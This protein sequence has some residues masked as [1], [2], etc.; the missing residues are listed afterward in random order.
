[1][2]EAEQAIAAA[3]AAR[4]AADIERRIAAAAAEADAAER[5]TSTKPT[6]DASKGRSSSPSRWKCVPYIFRR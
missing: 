3:E 4:Q 5:A 2:S 1:M 6:A